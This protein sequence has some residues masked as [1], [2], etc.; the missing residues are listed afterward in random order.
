MKLGH[1]KTFLR[2]VCVK[3]R[4]K[5]ENPR[6]KLG[7]LPYFPPS[8]LENPKS[9]RRFYPPKR[10]RRRK[11]PTI[12]K[13]D[14]GILLAYTGPIFH[15]T[16]RNKMEN[17]TGRALRQNPVVCCL[18]LHRSES[19]E[20]CAR[21][22]KQPWKWRR[23]EWKV[24]HQNGG[25]FSI[26]CASLQCTCAIFAFHQNS[27]TTRANLNGCRE[28]GE[29]IGRPSEQAREKRGKTCERTRGQTPVSGLGQGLASG[30]V[31]EKQGR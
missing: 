23:G 24:T 20:E 13:G 15:K 22:E 17:A 10:K 4:K 1:R 11:R 3:S 19:T 21:E 8:R 2:R 27:P 16:V 31:Q 5:E 25:F 9:A 30:R 18:L 26:V 29:K 28:K 12:F 14:Y 6:A 7:T